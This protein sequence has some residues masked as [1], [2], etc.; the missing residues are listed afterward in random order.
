M[1]F[2]KPLLDKEKRW[3][4]TAPEHHTYIGPA[5]IRRFIYFDTLHQ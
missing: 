1:N 5:R 2:A 3:K 4:F